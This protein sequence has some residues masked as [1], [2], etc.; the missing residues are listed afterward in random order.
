M[1]L[2]V[3]FV[4]GAKGG[5]NGTSKGRENL[6]NGGKVIYE[7]AGLRLNHYQLIIKHPKLVKMLW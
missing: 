4:C 6:L 7:V 1:L 2:C 3:G 5:D